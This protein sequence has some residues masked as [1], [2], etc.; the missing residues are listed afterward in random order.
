MNKYELYVAGKA[1]EF[2]AADDANP[3]VG[4]GLMQSSAINMAIEE[5][6]IVATLFGGGYDFALLQINRQTI[7]DYVRYKRK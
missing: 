6:K 4:W 7:E 1:F 3:N 5:M 2:L